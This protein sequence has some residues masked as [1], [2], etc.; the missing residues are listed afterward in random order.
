MFLSAITK[1]LNWEILIRI[2]LLLKDG[3]GLK[4]ESFNIIW[5]HWKIDFLGGSG[6]HKKNK[7]QGELPK[8]GGLD[9]LQ[10]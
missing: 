1:N 10:I 5:V 3:M 7:I 6:G 8:K 4:M 9:S 2:Q